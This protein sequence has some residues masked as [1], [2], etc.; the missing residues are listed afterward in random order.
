MKEHDFEIFLNK[1]SLLSS[2]ISTRIRH[3]KRAEKLLGIDLDNVVNDDDIMY[4]TL[5][6]L[7]PKDSQSHSHMQ[8]AVRKYYIFRNGKEFPRMNNYHSPKHP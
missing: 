7:K 5:K 8:N 2:A 3:A 6:K 4:E 1:E